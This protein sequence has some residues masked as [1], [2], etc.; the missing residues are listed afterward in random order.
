MPLVECKLGDRSL[1]PIPR[2]WLEPHWPPLKLDVGNFSFLL[3]LEGVWL[4]LVFICRVLL[5]KHL[6]EG[7]LRSQTLKIVLQWPE[8]R[9]LGQMRDLQRHTPQ[10]FVIRLCLY[11]V[12]FLRV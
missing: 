7:L 10:E 3:F 4:L 1:G 5:G 11:F 9:V 8:I 2:R 6:H 12:H